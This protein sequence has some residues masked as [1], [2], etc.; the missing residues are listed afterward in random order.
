MWKGASS[1]ALIAAVTSP[2]ERVV[3]PGETVAVTI[4]G[5]P[6][7]L[8]IDPAGFGLPIVTQ[9]FAE[10]AKL[11]C[12]GLLCFTIVTLI[13]RERLEGRTGV[14]KFGWGEAAPDKR[15]VGWFDR[16]FPTPVEGL[17]GPAGLPEP[18]VRFTLGPSRPGERT[19]A[20]P[21]EGN[22]LLF[23]HWQSTRGVLKV[24]GEDISV[25]FDVHGRRSLA[26]AGAAV[27]IA[28]AH[29][30]VMTDERD[31]QVIL[32]GVE[33]PIRVM[34]L[35]RPLTV[36][37]FSLTSLGVRV[38]DGSGAN[39][40]READA[41]PSEVVV[42]AKGKKSARILSIG[43]DQLDRCSSIVFDKPAKQIRLT[44]G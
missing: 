38:T 30:G 3:T 36:G 12:S 44:C 18:V 33:R 22:G 4:N 8:A 20:M 42:N 27:T 29:G 7:R 43:R 19:V 35:A 25:R 40:I 9:A 37:P 21:V 17:I 16:T 28:N 2:A 23:G 6:A 34:T 13:G 39:T 24:G 5:L 41:D 1:L 15:R 26:T 14:A 11:S 32:Y 10:Q 31:R